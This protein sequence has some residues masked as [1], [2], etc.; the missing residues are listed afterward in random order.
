V[1]RKSRRLATLDFETDPFKH[2]RTIRPFL[3]GFYDG[4]DFEYRWQDDKT[5]AQTLVNYLGTLPEKFLIYAHN[6]GKFDFLFLLKWMDDDPKIISG[7]VVECKIGGHI[8][9][10]SYAILP[11]K[12]GNAAKKLDIEISKLEAGRRDRHRAEIIDY[13]RQDCIGLHGAVAGFRARFGNSLTMAGAAMKRLKASV[14][15]ATRQPWTET[16]QRLPMARDVEFRRWYYGGRVDCFENGLIKAD[17]QVRDV[18]SMYP[19]VMKVYQ[20]PTG[21]DFVNQSAIDDRTDF[22]LVDAYSNRALPHRADNGSLSFPVGRGIFYATGHELRAGIELGKIRIFRV[23]TALR[24]TVKINFAS[25]VDEYYALRMAAREAGDDEAVLHFK[26]VL[27]S[28][29]GRFALDPERLYDWLVVGN[30]VSAFMRLSGDGYQIGFEGPHVTLWRRPVDEFTKARA[31]MNVATGA[32]I[33]GAARAELLRGI[34]R[35]DRPI[36]CDT[37]SLVCRSLDLPGGSDLGAWKHEAEADEAAIA[38]KKLYA[39]F[40]GGEAVKMASKGV[41]LTAAQIRD[42]AQGAT[43]RW[44]ADAPTF[45]VAGG[46]TY[47]TRDVRMTA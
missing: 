20:H 26:L 41:R 33:T 44:F 29:Y 8:L 35:A 32:S 18:N 43:V 22:A 10:D 47:L 31:I 27:N 16:L 21:R 23:I 4:V 14:E 37:D 15:R 34:A 30:D 6:G 12:L 25:F 7:R 17:M 36:Y 13:L 24:C 40:A 1:A 38:G 42:V 39:L 5:C 3:W 9:R 28:G 19:Y 45:N 2:G 46:W 11:V